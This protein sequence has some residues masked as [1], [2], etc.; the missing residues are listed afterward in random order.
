MNQAAEILQQISFTLEK[1][2]NKENKLFDEL[3]CLQN[4]DG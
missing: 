1:S 4:I 2:Q 3:Q